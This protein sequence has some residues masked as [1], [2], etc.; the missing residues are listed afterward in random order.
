LELSFSSRSAS[1]KI[2]YKELSWLQ[3]EHGNPRKYPARGS[4][5]F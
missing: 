4:M 3:K 1:L 2:I 5:A